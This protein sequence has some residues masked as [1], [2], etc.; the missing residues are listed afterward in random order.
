MELLEKT[1]Q[2]G[3]ISLSY[4]QG[5]NN[6]A[7]MVLLHGLTGVR[8]SWQDTFVAKYGPFWQQYAIDLRGHGKSSHAADEDAYL[9][10]NYVKDIVAFVESEIDQQPVIVGHSLGAMTAIGVGAA[11][12]A[13]VRALIL[14]DPPLAI[15]ELPTASLQGANAWFTQLYGILKDRPSYEQVVEICRQMVPPGDEKMLHAMA[16]QIHSLSPGTVKIALKD[17]I[18]EGFDF[19]EALDDVT[20]PVLLMHAQ[21]G[22]SGC[23]RDEDA[24]FVGQHTRNLT[25]VKLPYDDH[26]FFHTYWEETHPHVTTFLETL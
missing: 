21:F 23:L 9:M 19:G 18:L 25:T 20:C 17:R 15:R 4:D 11:L 2:A 10:V 1:F 22:Q 12:G 7:P 3:E 8:Q 14:L 16:T 6:G 5:P 26:G 13:R 24:A